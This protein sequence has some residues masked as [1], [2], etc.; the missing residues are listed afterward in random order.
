MKAD[1]FWNVGSVCVWW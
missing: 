1:C